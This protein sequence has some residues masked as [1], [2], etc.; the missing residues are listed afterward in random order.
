MSQMISSLRVPGRQS[1]TPFQ[2]GIL[3]S[4]AALKQLLEDLKDRFPSIYYIA[5][6]RLN[7]D[8]VEN[9]FSALRGKGGVYDHPTRS[10]FK[11]RLR[12]YILGIHI[13]F[14]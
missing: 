13:Y 14:A 12:K 8:L 2:D 11:N 3:L 5:G 10:E 6:S 7:Q 1:K 4:N 9:F